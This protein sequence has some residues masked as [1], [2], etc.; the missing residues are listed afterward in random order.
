MVA[1]SLEVLGRTNAIGLIGLLECSHENEIFNFVDYLVDCRLYRSSVFG[2]RSE[3]F[4]I[5]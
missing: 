3:M 2:S 5:G 4:L 1:T